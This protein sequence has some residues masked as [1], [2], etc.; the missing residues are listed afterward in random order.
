MSRR[1]ICAGLLLASA[2]ALGGCASD[3][4]R[5]SGPVPTPSTSPSGE[6][7]TVTPL[8]AV[9]GAEPRTVDGVSVDVPAGW[10]LDRQEG[11]DG[12]TQIMVYDP[13]DDMNPVG[14]TVSSADATDGAVSLQADVTWTQLGA[15]G[16]TDLERHPVDW[17]AWADGVGITG[18]V[19]RD[20]GA[21]SSFVSVSTRDEDGNL[22]VSISAQSADG[23]LEESLQ[24][25]VL[26]T[27]RP[28]S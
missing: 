22:L 5:G 18:L 9:D 28:A 10:V 11:D 17:S 12:T 8:E 19:A 14:I 2:L 3:E 23:N 20:T 26:R 7:L 4:P 21:D 24:Y 27:V 25:Q 16:V 6:P 13:A 15:S 1:W